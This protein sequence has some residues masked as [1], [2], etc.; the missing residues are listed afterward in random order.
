VFGHGTG[1]VDALLVGAGPVTAVPLFLFAYGA[2]LIPYSTLGLIQYFAPSLQLLAGIFL[3]GEPFHGARAVGFGL[4]W[5]A[6]VVYAGEGF[7]R[8]RR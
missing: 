8:A 3:Y 4:I 6:L 7:W 5:M 1:V 2:R